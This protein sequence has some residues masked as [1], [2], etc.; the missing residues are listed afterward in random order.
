MLPYMMVNTVTVALLMMTM[1][2]M[3]NPLGAQNVAWVETRRPDVVD[4][5]LFRSLKLVS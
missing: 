5:Q 1:I 4:L 3:E 2:G